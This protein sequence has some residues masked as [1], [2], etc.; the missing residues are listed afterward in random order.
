[1]AIFLFS[2]FKN[3]YDT[4]KEFEN[5]YERALY[6]I[7]VEKDYQGAINL[8]GE[9]ESYRDS[10]MY[11][12]TANN[13]IQFETAERL[14]K[15]GQYIEARDTFDTLANIGDFEGAKIAK[16]NV[17]EIDSLLADLQNKEN[18]YNNALKSF[19]AE[20][21]L[22]ASSLFNELGDYKDSKYLAKTSDKAVKILQNST[23]ISAGVVFS[24]GVTEE[25]RVVSSG[26]IILSQSD[27]EEWRDIVSISV[28]GSL[29]IGL[30]PDG[31]VLTA[32]KLDNDYRIETGN[33]NDIIAVAAGDLYVVGL[34]ENGT[35]VAQGYNG[36]GQMDIDEWTD[37]KAISTG[38]RHTVGL[39][40]DGKVCIAG[41]RSE[42][43]EKI[44][45][46]KEWNG[47]VSISAGG[48]KPGVEGENGHTVGLKNT[49]KVVA[50]GDNGKG[51]CDVDEWEDIIAI[52]AGAFHTV[53]LSKDGKVVT[54][55]KDSDILKEVNEWE[56]VV[57][58]E[59]GYGTTFAI[60]SD[61]TVLSA[62]YDKQHQ[63]DTDN[64]EKLAI[65]EKEW[66]NIFDKN[67]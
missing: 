8:L 41:I 67:E 13:W 44:K 1:M 63:R 54:T 34:R 60:R 33:W 62:G 12:D 16:K 49:G 36:V 47:I 28:F 11:I 66:K 26:N 29:A 21:Y 53:G 58:V 51:Q 9:L 7:S 22:T 55:Q 2:Y 42:D 32:G 46:S 50:I 39:T 15:D 64:W 25:G 14:Y 31:T 61:G 3:I 30:K 20:D 18:I 24:A 48:G 5:K 17:R 56:D 10:L 57:A 4:R 35:L 38:W 45:N 59:A 37:I 40:K 19:E 6:K 65:H 27:V 23:T 43:E 52:S